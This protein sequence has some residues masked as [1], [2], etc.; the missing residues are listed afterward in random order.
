[1]SDR[2][3]TAKVVAARAVRAVMTGDIDEI[4]QVYGHDVHLHHRDAPSTVG[5]S[6]VRE[7]SLTFSSALWDC[8]VSVVFAMASD[9]VV[10][11]RWSASAIQNGSLFGLRATRRPTRVE[12]ITVMRVRAGRVVEEWTEY[13]G[14]EPSRHRAPLMVR[15]DLASVAG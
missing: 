10:V 2:I 7:R 1:M 5:V 13:C 15:D 9:D 3:P 4:A 12:G 6:A 11:T 8:A 14:T